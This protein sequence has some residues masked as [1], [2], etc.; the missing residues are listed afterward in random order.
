MNSLA[1]YV[2]SNR[3]SYQNAGCRNSGLTAFLFSSSSNRVKPPAM[4]PCGG[5]HAHPQLSS[6]LSIDTLP[7]THDILIDQVSRATQ[8]LCITSVQQPLLAIPTSRTL[9]P[10]DVGRLHSCPHKEVMVQL[11]GLL[12][13]NS[14]YLQRK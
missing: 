9:P 7:S 6:N 12:E 8:A 1:S 4:L 11:L 14:M 10:F 5:Q 13:T 3:N 2:Y